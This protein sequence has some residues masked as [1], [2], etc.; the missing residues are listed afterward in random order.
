M[1]EETEEREIIQLP[2]GTEAGSDGSGGTHGGDP[3]LRRCG[4]GWTAMQGDSKVASASG[5][6]LGAKQT[7]P[8]AELQAVADFVCYTTG[9]AIV[10]VDCKPVLT[11]L[12]Q[13]T[14]HTWS[15]NANTP[16]GDLWDIV[17]RRLLFRP[18]VLTFLKVKAHLE[19]E[20]AVQLGYT[21]QAWRLN[22]IAD[23]LADEA[24]NSH[25]L[26]NYIVKLVREMDK[27]A[28][29]VQQRLMAIHWTIFEHNERSPMIK[30]P[31][32]KH[33]P[34]RTRVIRTAETNGHLLQ[35][36]KSGRPVRCTKCKLEGGL[37]KGMVVFGKPCTGPTYGAG[38]E[39]R[40]V[41]GLQ[42]CWKCGAYTATGIIKGKL[43]KP[44]LNRPTATSVTT[45]SRVQD[46]LLPHGFTTSH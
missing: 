27:K 36:I 12:Q 30:I 17:H 19:E 29:L 13:L 7:V 22:D 23:K 41:H 28:E 4:W 1:P 33:I 3:R 14:A 18:G 45:L 44:C 5:P 39:V 43:G 8:R 11:K 20:E 2:P 37:R 35:D 34:L 9:D 31:K 38:H 42:I 24:A 21:R 46:D 40:D 15:P 26:D 10:H 25:Q 6:L 16:N 32:P